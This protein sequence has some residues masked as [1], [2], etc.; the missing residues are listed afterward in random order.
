MNDVEIIAAMR[1]HGGSFVNL[2]ARAWVA[3]DSDNRAR[4]KRT[5]PEYWT[6]YGEKAQMMKQKESGK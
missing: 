6:A 1:N 5:W 3:A 2:L 4:I